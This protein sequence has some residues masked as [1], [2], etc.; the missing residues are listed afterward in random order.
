MRRLTLAFLLSATTA[1][2]TELPV[3]SVTLSSA[4]LAQVERAGEVPPDGTVTFRAPTEDVDD[5]L[6]SLIVVDTAGT[7]E[8]L[9]LPA[10]DLANEAFRGLP[11]RPDDFDSRVRLLA[12]LRGQEAEAGGARGRIAD[13]AEVPPVAGTPG[14]LRLTLITPTGLR[15]VVL[16]EGDEVV[17]TDTALAGR[18]ARAAEALAAARSNDERRIE[19]RLR[20]D[21]AR[22]VAVLY[23]AGAPLWKPSYRLLVPPMGAPA[24]TPTQARL[25]GW[26]VVE[27]A[28]GSDW[29]AVRLALV[30][31]EAA[32]FRQRIYQPITVARP[33]M[34]V[35][36]AGAVM[37]TPDTG[38][39]PVPIPMPAP[40]PAALA[41]RMMDSSAAA[42]QMAR[43]AG[44][45]DAPGM[46]AG[47][48]PAQPAAAA[49]AEASAGRVAFVLAEPVTIRAGETA[50]VPFLDVRLPAERVWWIQDLNAR[51]PLQAVR[52]RNGSPHTL[53]DGLATVYG[54]EGPEA[55]VFLGDAEI[56]AMPSGDGR[57]L[58]FARDRDVQ[59]AQSGTSTDT[60]RGIALR[61][62]FVAIDIARREEV[63]LAVDP[64]GARGMVVVDVPARAGATPRFP[65]VSQGD[66]GLRHEAVLDGSA[67]T[68]R[69][70]F[71]RAIRQDTPL[72]D[73][74]LGEPMLLRWQQFDIEQN[75]RRLPGGPGT[76]E[77]LQEILARTPPDVPGRAD[78][79]AVVEAMQAL[80]RQLDEARLRARAY[81]AADQ[82]LA[83]AR[84]AAEDRTGP[85]QQEARRRLNQASREA[86]AAGS[87]A[88]QAWE[89]WQR[90]VVALL[91]RGS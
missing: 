89:A 37:V 67:Q 57:I 22:Q 36:V 39:V 5:L 4:G 69:L 24:A 66:F 3:R 38:G 15:T 45:P 56:R 70:A 54:A 30:S 72:W 2:A 23:V 34:P 9:R 63:A 87:A 10:R 85:E 20:A 88:D 74:S 43:R 79:A 46:I 78:L 71:E 80:R 41:G 60:V 27:N 44:A 26:A 64:R 77:R 16:R 75:L 6:R 86:E 13:A 33:E 12:A 42:P 68:I 59:V 47:G 31:G 50:N 83:R 8:G 49:T 73:T 55:G 1:L 52:I 17:L 7:V 11:V 53:P 90:G 51:H 91:Q 28:S 84:Q 32:A 61:R 58:A 40:A 48:A 35:R 14:G 65:I 19:I 25:Q 76:M 62:G 29:D 18:V 81:R 82:A 21:R